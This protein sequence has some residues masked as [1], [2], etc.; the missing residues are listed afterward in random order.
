MDI[1]QKVGLHLRKGDLLGIV[2]AKAGFLRSKGTILR[3]NLK[4]G[5]FQEEKRYSR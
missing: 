4:Y 1:L 5:T 2:F 3:R